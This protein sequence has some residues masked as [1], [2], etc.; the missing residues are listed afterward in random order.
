M[1]Y[2]RDLD[3]YSEAELQGEINYRERER[4]RG[5]CDY[6][7]RPSSSNSCKYSARHADPRIKKDS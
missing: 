2:W 1:G 4:Q 6:C 3:D 5:R 7:H